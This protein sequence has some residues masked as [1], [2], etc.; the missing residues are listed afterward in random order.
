MKL[1]IKAVIAKS[2][3][4]SVLKGL[5]VPFLS[6]QCLPNKASG[7]LLLG[8]H[9]PTSCYFTWMHSNH[10][11]LNIAR[12]KFSLSPNWSIFQISLISIIICQ[13]MQTWWTPTNLLPLASDPES[14]LHFAS[15]W[16]ALLALN[17]LCPFSSAP[18]S[19]SR[20]FCPSAVV[21]TSVYH[22]HL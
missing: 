17:H 7:F 8:P 2:L 9:L 5:I 12:G 18:H 14:Y 4:G 15:P 11:K 1:K 3:T 19:L 6:M 10:L 21:P 16:K 20:T 13:L 22:I